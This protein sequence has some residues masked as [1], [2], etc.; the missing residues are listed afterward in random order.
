MYALSH[1][2]VF[3]FLVSQIELESLRN[4]IKPL[5][6]FILIVLVAV[7]ILGIESS[8]DDTSVALVEA[9]APTSPAFGHLSSGRR[10]SFEI[11]AEKTASQIE[12]H[13][14]YGGVVPE[15][16]GRC[17]AE[18]ILPLIEEVMNHLTPNPSPCKGEGGIFVMGVW[19]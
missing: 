5:Y 16:A 4:L 18:N 10:G 2:I 11:L 9:E 7:L 14:K 15:I 3:F 17:H 6:I 19:G 1:A 12:V 8:C 13:K